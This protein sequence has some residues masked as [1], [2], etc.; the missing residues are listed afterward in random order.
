MTAF[1]QVLEDTITFQNTLGSLY[2]FKRILKSRQMLVIIIN[3]LSM[4]IFM[5]NTLILLKTQASH[6][7]IQNRN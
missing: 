2:I 1:L 5:G 7:D 4:Y 3:M 6:Q